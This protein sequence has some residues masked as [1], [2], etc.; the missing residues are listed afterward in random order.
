MYAYIHIYGYEER[1][2]NISSQFQHHELPKTSLD[3]LGTD[4]G[5]GVGVG[6]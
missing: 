6:V 5:A 4:W 1:S 3:R 2:L